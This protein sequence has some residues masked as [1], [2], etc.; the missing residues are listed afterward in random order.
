MA[1]TINS[2]ST[3]ANYKDFTGS[4]APRNLSIYNRMKGIGDFGNLAQY[5]LLETGYSILVVLTR[6]KFLTALTNL[7]STKNNTLI[8]DWIFNSQDQI[9]NLMNSFCDIIEY[10]F[11]GLDGI[12][13][14]TADTSTITDGINELNMITKVTEDTSISVTMSFYEKS[15][16]LITKFVKFYLKG[17][18]DSRSQARTYYGLVNPFCT[19]TAQTLEP[20]YENE[21][22][23]MLY[24]VTDNTLMRLEQA[25]LLL[26]CQFTTASTSTYE[27]SKGE[28]AYKEISLPMNCFPVTSVKVNEK[29]NK[30]LEYL[31]TTKTNDGYNLISDDF[32]YYGT[33]DN[34]IYASG[35]TN[36]ETVVDYISGRIGSENN[37]GGWRQL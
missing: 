33:S 6:P 10:E 36:N 28:I 34:S 16:S 32:D 35:A 8:P 24:M 12:P 14:I 19:D 30:M 31:M 3:N 1:T 37:V 15:G 20:G 7:G 13:D 25:Y 17:L 23:T 21:V 26:N 2:S 22:F 27:S 4:K 29:A 18:K 5:D 11:R 9:K